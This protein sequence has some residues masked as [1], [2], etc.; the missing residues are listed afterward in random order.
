MNQIDTPAPTLFDLLAR[1]WR[2]SAAV[3]TV[4][5][6][7]DLSAVAFACADGSLTIAPMDD[8]EPPES[9]I[10]VSVESG[11]STIVPRDKA[12][13]PASIVEPFGGLPLTIA[14]FGA[15]GFVAGGAGGQLVRIDPRGHVTP[16]AAR[17]NGPVVGLAHHAAS[18]RT[19]CAAAGAVALFQGEDTREPLR[20]APEARVAALALSPD[21]SE[22]ALAHAKGLSLWRLGD[23]PALSAEIP[24]DGDPVGLS[25][26]PDGAWIACTLA[27]DG[28]R[29]VR[30][31]D[32]AGETLSKYPTPVH[33]FAWN[34]AENALATSGAFRVAAWSLAVPPLDGDIRGVLQT[35]RSG[36]VVVESVAAHPSR[37][38]LAVGYANG[39]VNIAQIGKPDELMILQDGSGAINALAW[40]GDGRHVALGT[41]D[42]KAAIV[43]FPSNM[44]K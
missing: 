14:P 34:R 13:P 41:A 44:F 32:G 37:N 2:C 18:G 16:F 10:R 21:G 39:L 40:S 43:S 27:A 4:T 33:S 36:L 38:L 3:A 19:A 5:F 17:M 8:A 28:F 29:L 31:S 1:Q 30:L 22:L 24:F 35:G 23:S 6:N 26:S 11:R 15:S 9:R 20:F 7:A 12:I 42:G 25:W